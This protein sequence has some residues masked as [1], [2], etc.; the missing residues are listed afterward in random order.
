[1]FPF[2]GGIGQYLLPRSSVEIDNSGRTRLEY[3]S[4]LKALGTEIHPLDT[5]PTEVLIKV[6]ERYISYWFITI[7][8][9]VNLFLS[10]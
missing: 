4:I 2:L 6:S 10:F 8:C 7:S 5:L 1:M 3:R 9:P